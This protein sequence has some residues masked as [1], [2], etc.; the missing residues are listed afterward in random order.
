VF[1]QTMPSAPYCH[2]TN[3]ADTVT[4]LKLTSQLGPVA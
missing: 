4:T 2:G 3:A 1:A